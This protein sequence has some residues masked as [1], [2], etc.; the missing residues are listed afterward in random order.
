MIPVG[1]AAFFLTPGLL[2]DIDYTAFPLSTSTNAATIDALIAAAGRTLIRASP[3]SVQ[4][5]A[6]ALV[7]SGIAANNAR[8]GSDGGGQ[9][10][11]IEVARSPILPQ[12]E[13]DFAWTTYNLTDVGLLDPGPD[14]TEM[15]R[16]L[17]VA[18][19]PGATDAS[20]FYK[21]APLNPTTHAASIWYQG[22]VG[23]ENTYMCLVNEGDTLATSAP[24]ALTT[25]WQRFDVVRATPNVPTTNWFIE[26]G[27]DRNTGDQGATPAL[28][29][30]AAKA[31][32]EE[33]TFS[34]E[35]MDV[36]RAADNYFG[37]TTDVLDAGRIG[38]ELTFIPKFS[39]AS[40]P[41]GMTITLW[42]LDLNN[43]VYMM[44]TGG[45]VVVHSIVGGADYACPTNPSWS[46]GDVL[47]FW[48]AVGGGAL[49]SVLEYRVGAGAGIVLGVSGAPQA[50]LASGVPLYLL[51]RGGAD[52][53]TARLQRETYYPS[54]S[55]PIWL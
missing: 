37:L 11:V 12:L 15:S 3:A 34:T 6:D 45:V 35:W 44:K 4:T 52:V 29:L 23:G 27:T 21:G 47:T 40:M 13:V 10:L 36:A 17:D 20:V 53:L 39:S 25:S 30:N 16:R 18:A 41:E 2:L 24:C 1:R 46:K 55:S 7:A 50:A 49:Q 33:G 26:L 19:C 31:Q 51:G 8:I 14:A 38:A 32:L 43:R 28:S 48:M 9:G 22:I 42:A 54:A 5:G